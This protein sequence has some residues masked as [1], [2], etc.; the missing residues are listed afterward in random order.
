VKTGSANR[1]FPGSS[2][3]E[4]LK[5]NTGEDEGDEEENEEENEEEEDEAEEEE[6]QDAAPHGPHC[7]NWRDP[8][9]PE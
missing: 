4:S 6:D 2:K 5:R 3:G 8:G 1:G 9:D 7:L